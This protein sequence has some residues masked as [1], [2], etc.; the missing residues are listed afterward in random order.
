MM[1]DTNNPAAVQDILLFIS[2]KWYSPKRASVKIASAYRYKYLQS[3]TISLFVEPIYTNL[4][5]SK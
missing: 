3:S 2:A 4:A 5:S 1:P